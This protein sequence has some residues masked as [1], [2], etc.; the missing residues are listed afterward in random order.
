MADRK[1]SSFPRVRIDKGFQNR[2]AEP[3][4]IQGVRGSKFESIPFPAPSFFLPFRSP[5]PS[6]EKH[7]HS[8]E[9]LRS[10]IIRLRPILPPGSHDRNRD[11]SPP[12]ASPPA[13]RSIAVR[14]VGSAHRVL[15]FL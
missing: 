15:S 9:N 4:P 12:S 10:P 5:A 8:H 11:P 1:N 14:I 2:V 13:R 3:I 6:I 7:V